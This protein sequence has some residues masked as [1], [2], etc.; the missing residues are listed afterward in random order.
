MADHCPH[1]YKLKIEKVCEKCTKDYNP[2]F[3]FRL[4][5]KRCFACKECGWF[6]AIMEEDVFQGWKPH[7]FGA[8]VVKTTTYTAESI[9]TSLTQK[10]DT[11]YIKLSTG[12]SSNW[13]C[14]HRTA[15]LFCLSQ[16]LS[17]ELTALTCPDE[18]RRMQLLFFN[19]KARAENDLYAIVALAINNYLNG[20]TN[21]FIGK[22]HGPI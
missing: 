10:W 6:K 16:W 5:K 13:K 9:K 19:Q 12:Q 2:S 8:G 4:C 18:D 21:K 22:Y 7:Q 14:D 3:A 15:E 17:D 11:Y 1:S 20:K